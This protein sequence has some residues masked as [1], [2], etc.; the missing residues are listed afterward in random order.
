[1]LTTTPVAVP[2]IISISFKQ[3]KMG[4]VPVPRMFRAMKRENDNKPKVGQTSCELG[5]RPNEVDTD[6][7]GNALVNEKG[8]SVAPEWRDLPIFFIPPRLGTGGRGKNSHSC[9]RRGAG[10]FQQGACGNGL[11]LMPDSPVHGVVRPD[12]VVPLADYLK[13]LADTR[14]EWEI[15]EN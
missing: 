14:E 6:G 9:F 11:E 2:G 7:Q 5:V 1:V 10:A 15:D 3:T 8:R 4:D 12:Q 13:N